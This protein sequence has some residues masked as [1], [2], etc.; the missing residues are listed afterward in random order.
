MKPEG[1]TERRAMPMTKKKKERDEKGRFLPGHSQSFKYHP[2]RINKSGFWKPEDSISYQ[3]KHLVKMS[4]KE[5]NEWEKEHPEEERTVAQQ[6][7]YKAIQKAIKKLSYLKEVTDRTEGKAQQ[8][9]DVQS[10]G[11]PIVPLLDYTEKK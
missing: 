10:G 5:F 3:Y 9:V 1:N 7:A 8:N 11:R 6:A 4:V 2:E